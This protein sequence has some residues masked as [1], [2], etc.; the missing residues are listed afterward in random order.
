M[1]FIFIFTVGY[2]MIPKLVQM[3]T[4]PLIGDCLVC[5]CSFFE[6]LGLWC[7]YMLY[8]I[9]SSA[10]GPILEDCAT[11]WHWNYMALRYTC[12]KGYNVAFKVA[13]K[14]EMIGPY[15]EP[16][17]SPTCY[18]VF[19]GGSPPDALDMRYYKEWVFDHSAVNYT[20]WESHFN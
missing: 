1:S 7:C 20:E 17:N 14:Q 16:A 18:P 4:V 5:S 15:Y 8:V 12:S 19:F 6:R 3:R 11:R 13:Q 2:P 10:G 9:C